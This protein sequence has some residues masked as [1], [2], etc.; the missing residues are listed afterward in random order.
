MI[1]FPSHTVSHV[2]GNK[3]KGNESVAEQLRLRQ[4]ADDI[5]E[6]AKLGQHEEFLEKW[7]IVHRD[8]SGVAFEN[9]LNCM[10]INT[11]WRACEGGNK[12]VFDLLF[13][14][15]LKN[16][17]NFFACT[18]YPLEAAAT[19]NHRELFLHILRTIQDSS[20]ELP[21]G[22]KLDG[23]FES[24]VVYGDVVMAKALLPFVRPK[25]GSSSFLRTA[26]EHKRYDMIDLLLPLSNIDS[27]LSYMR[28]RKTLTDDDR[29]VLESIKQAK[30]DKDLL[31]S[32]VGDKK[33]TSKRKMKM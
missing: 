12:N 1:V 21:Q 32:K 29:S 11:L 3:T 15:V 23:V 9:I 18:L 26:C 10:Y 6:A 22:F 5:P 24:V 25:A 33:N 20:T 4:L 7:D 14:I 27:A 16:S 19:E 8:F 30:N 13:P 17:D 2:L 28:K 31:L